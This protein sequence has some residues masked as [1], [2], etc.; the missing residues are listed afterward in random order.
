[1]A[2]MKKEQLLEKEST[3]REDTRESIWR[4]KQNKW[5]MDPY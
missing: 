4:G 2:V 5:A 1:M 3:R